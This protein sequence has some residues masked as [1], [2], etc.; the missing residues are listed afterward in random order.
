M[1]VVT[2]AGPNEIDVHSND[3]DAEGQPTGCT[4]VALRLSSA[5]TPTATGIGIYRNNILRGGFC[6]TRVLVAETD[7]AAD[8]RIFEHND[9]DPFNAPQVLY[10]DENTT[11][12][13]SAMA[14][15]Q[16]TDMIVSG[17]LSVDALYASYPADLHLQAGSMCIDGGTASG[18]PLTDFEG[19]PRD[20]TPD[21]G[22]D[23]F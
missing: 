22:A 15:D 8:P 10:L 21:I 11:Q 23:E 3:L 18:A 12:L 9:L 1:H 16:L 19:E 4:G 13:N 20:A 17:T 7:G 5:G 2:Q 14:V 6:N